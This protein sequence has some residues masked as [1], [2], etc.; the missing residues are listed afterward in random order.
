MDATEAPTGVRWGVAAT[1]S[2]SLGV[3]PRSDWARWIERGE[4]PPSGDGS[5]F[6]VDFASDLE[7]FAESGITRLRWTI[8][9]A[10]LEPVQ[11]RP[12]ADAWDLTRE[13]LRAAR[14]VGI[15]VWAVLMDGPLPGWFADDQRGW[16]DRDGVVRTWPRH[17]DRI[18]EE[19]G[20]LIGAWIPVL[21]PHTWATNGF[22]RGTRPPGIVDEE[23]FLTA[24]RNVHLASNEARRLLT[25]GDAPVVCC[26]DHSPA[27]VGVRSRE[28]DERDAARALVDRHERL[29][30]GVWVRALND[31]VLSIPDLGEVEI[32]GLAGGYDTIGLTWRGA[33][34]LFADGTRGPY[35]ADATRAADGRAPWTEGLGVAV[36]R[37]ADAFPRRTLA[38]LG[39]GLVAA[40]DDWRSEVIDRSVAEL[41][42][43][44]VDGVRID[45][46]FWESGIDGW[47]PACG[48]AVPDGVFDRSRHPRPSAAALRRGAGA[49]ELRHG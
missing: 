2:G 6:G 31:G 9:W 23:E 28:P 29:Q 39:T 32:D 46:A 25:S 14:R 43:A 41:D 3:A 45:A 38:L 19:F 11:G 12:D 44:T 35:P 49:R 4:L 20:D 10:R 27:H 37:L 24:L 5:G 21:D 48:L 15:E 7:L 47:T 34:T 40:E 1:G 42:A 36:R 17:V 13:I 22:A 18:A 33:R 30:L 26:I 8:D 16:R